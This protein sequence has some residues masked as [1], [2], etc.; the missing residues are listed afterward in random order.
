M[1]ATGGEAGAGN[2][3]DDIDLPRESEEMADAATRQ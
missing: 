1:A 3:W 2:D